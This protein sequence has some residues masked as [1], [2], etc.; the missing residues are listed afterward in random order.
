MNT[1]KRLNCY[2]FSNLIIS[3]LSL[4][5]LIND[6]KT[7]LNMV[8]NN[9]NSMFQ[10]VYEKEVIALGN[11]TLKETTKL[12]V[13][14]KEVVSKKTIPYVK[15]TY[16]SVTGSNLVSYAKRYLGLN[17]VYGGNSLST[18]TDCSGF[19]QLIYKE[20]GISLGRT[21]NS[22]LYN[23]VYVNKADLKPGDLVFY[24]KTNYATHVAIYIGNGLVI[25]ESTPR[26]G[27][28]I[29]SVDMMVYITARRL[30]T[31]SV[32]TQEKKN[33]TPK[34]D[35]TESKDKQDTKKDDTK[36]EN[37]ND[38]D[39]EIDIKEEVKVPDKTPSEN[40]VQE[41]NKENLNK[42]AS[43]ILEDNNIN[44]NIQEEKTTFDKEK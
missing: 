42:T 36:E 21:V 34:K 1:K 10:K 16:N 23:G 30:I 35:T 41:E 8:K 14:K 22:Q 25:H 43:D 37:K 40:I 7:T 44:N 11:E 26:N 32:T 5:F 28:K 29:D 6:T 9:T 18:G 2:V 39:K 20:F 38:L 33:E 4:N 15:P 3:F 24:G 13:T 19:T 27:V 17:Y 12:N 31:A